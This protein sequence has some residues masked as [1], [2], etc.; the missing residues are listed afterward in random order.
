MAQRKELRHICLTGFMGSGKSTIGKILSKHFRIQF[1]DTDDRIE[2]AEGMSVKEIFRQK[3]EDFFRKKE[4]E[5]I[6]RELDASEVRII[7]LGGGALMHNPNREHV[8]EKALLIYIYSRPEEIYQR[9]KHSTKRPLFR[10]DNEEITEEQSLLRIRDL[11]DQRAE[12]YSQADIVFD[13]DQMNA[14]EAAKKLYDMI[15]NGYPEFQAATG[16]NR[17]NA[18]AE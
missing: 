14:E 10:A 4:T 7:S 18:N 6:L 5:H 17:K 11:M 9:I 12:G 16:E 8:R 15:R 2:S 13:R 3:G 1:V